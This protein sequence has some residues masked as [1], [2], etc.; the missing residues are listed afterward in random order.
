[1][2]KITM[3]K[4]LYSA[5]LAGLLGLSG[6]A[7]A[8]G[9]AANGEKLAAQGYCYTCH[10]DKGM[11]MSRNAPPL[12]GQSVQYLSKALNDYKT[13]A[14][15]IDNKSLGMQAV[16][17]PLTASN[18]ADLAAFYSM[19]KAPSSKVSGTPPASAGGCMGCHA[20]NGKPGMGGTA[21]GLAGMSKGYIARQLHA[22]KS[23]KRGDGMMKSLMSSLTSAQIDEIASYYGGN[24]GK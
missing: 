9:N 23:G 24:Q 10:G 15:H 8:A 5:T 22:F 6:T 20:A 2:T 17:K 1:M 13:A 3:N 18:I 16:A 12:A 19:Q 7:M 14:F 21:P 4:I 11:P